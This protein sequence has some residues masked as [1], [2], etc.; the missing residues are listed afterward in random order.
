MFRKY[1][2]FILPF[3]IFCFS[4]IV[5]ANSDEPVYISTKKELQQIY[6]EAIPSIV[7]ITTFEKDDKKIFGLR[8]VGQGSG[9]I[10]GGNGIIVTA[11][12]IAKGA[13]DIQVSFNNGKLYN[14]KEI[15]DYDPRLDVCLLKIDTEDLP[16]VLFGDDN[17]LEP[18]DKVF[19][20]G[21][22]QGFEYSISDGLFASKRITPNQVCLQFT[23]PISPGNSGGPLFD[24]YGN[25]IGMIIKTQIEGQNINFALS[26]NQLKKFIDTSRS[27]PIPIQKFKQD[28]QENYNWYDTVY[29]LGQRQQ[30][31]KEIYKIY[32]MALDECGG[33]DDRCLWL[34][35]D[36]VMMA[37]ATAA[38][39]VSENKFPEAEYYCREAISIIE[40]FGGVQRMLA[41]I[42]GEL[43][44]TEEIIL[45]TKEETFAGVYYLLGLTLDRYDLQGLEYCIETIKFISPNS[46][47]IS[48]LESLSDFIKKR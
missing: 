4:P 41:R 39:Y 19:S 30:D 17:S 28:W 47:K 7:V 11:F 5:I 44:L 20:I 15:V 8:E 31:D 26:A 40:K 12:H 37:V 24:A 3:L 18:G 14:V 10:V 16:P 6:R 13:D 22:P 2:L 32:K 25:V 9:F 45:E 23:A 1:S 42:E 33:R 21:A 29:A 27:I 36:T 38:P 35:L 46:R 48:T 34:G 43:P